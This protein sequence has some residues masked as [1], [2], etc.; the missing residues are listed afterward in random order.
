M[1]RILYVDQAE[2]FGGSLVVAGMLVN[3]LDRA[4]F[5]PSVA[6]AF[7]DEFTQ[8]LFASAEAT[9]KARS[10]LTYTD[11]ERLRARVDTIKWA[12]LRKLAGLLLSFL[13]VLASTKHCL[14]LAMLILRKRIAVVHSNNSAEAVVAALITRRPVIFHLHGAF[15]APVVARHRFMFRRCSA[16]VA[17][18][19]YVKET[20]VRAGLDASQIEIVPNG[21]ELPR[22]GAEEAAATRQRWGIEPHEP[23]VA[24]VG[25]VVEW[26]GHREFVLAAAEVHKRYPDAHFMF[27]G[28]VSDGSPRFLAEL[29]DLARELGLEDR[30]H[31]TGYVS[32]VSAH[33]A[34]ANVI[35]HASIEPEPFGLVII[36]GMAM[37]R[38]VVASSLGAGPEIIT[39]GVDGLLADPRDSG[40]LAGAICRLLDDKNFADTIG[41]QART[42]VESKYRASVMARNFERIYERVASRKR[43]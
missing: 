39:D 29:Y 22:V 16:L 30:L 9:Y 20:A 3:K 26:K 28:D 34:A 27:V 8:R 5:S 4:A 18:S 33:I 41:R 12:W 13:D 31:C 35:V 17:I 23:L 19:K 36:E 43:G 21:T 38:P 15:G 6:I 24:L 42:T 14:D 25:R 32:N 11:M 10:A 2:A 1:R 37:G 7:E 40:M